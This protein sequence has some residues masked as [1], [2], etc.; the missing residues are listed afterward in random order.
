MNLEEMLQLQVLKFKASMA[1]RGSLLESAIENADG[2]VKPVQ[3]CAK[4]S[5]ELF[6]Q[7]ENVCGMLDLTK[8]EF[9]EAA[10]IEAVHIAN[11]YIATMPD[12]TEQQRIG[13][14]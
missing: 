4:V 6:D 7:V 11:K 5:P 1:G 2:K 13:G 12:P 10:V 3:M 9:I 8:R 14:I